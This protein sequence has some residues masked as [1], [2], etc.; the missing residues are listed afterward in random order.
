MSSASESESEDEQPVSPKKEQPKQVDDDEESRSYRLLNDAIGKIPKNSTKE[1]YR[2]MV[3]N[4]IERA[5]EHYPWKKHPIPLI[6]RIMQNP[7]LCNYPTL[8]QIVLALFPED[9]VRADRHGIKAFAYAVKSCDNMYIPAIL[10][11]AN[12]VNSEL[13]V[14][15]TMLK[16]PEYEWQRAIV[17]LALIKTGTSVYNALKN[18]P[19]PKQRLKMK[20]VCLTFSRGNFAFWDASK[21]VI[22]ANRLRKASST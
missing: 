18:V 10:M 22:V 21:V 14:Y 20:R 16:K 5:C 19:D 17:I 2:R 8:I 11:Q 3:I 4:T 9:S 6:I 1:Q 12:A 7:W 13:S 15:E